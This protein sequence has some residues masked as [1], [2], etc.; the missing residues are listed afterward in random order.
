[1]FFL[2]S[3]DITDLPLPMLQNYTDGHCLSMLRRCAG[4]GARAPV[5]GR[6]CA[7]A[8]GRTQLLRFL[9]L[10]D[11]FDEPNVKL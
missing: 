6:R 11:G 1:M 8:P 3:H 2:D 7:G 5:R 10:E 9:L 4:A